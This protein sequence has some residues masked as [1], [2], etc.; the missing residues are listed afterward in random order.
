[1]SLKA[2]HILFIVLS[3]LLSVGCAV[4]AF[5]NG[6]MVAFGTGSSVV[7]LALIIYGINF[8]KK[9]RRIIT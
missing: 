2:F 4:W 6:P 3:I 1:M 8:L 5:A 7:A 9:A